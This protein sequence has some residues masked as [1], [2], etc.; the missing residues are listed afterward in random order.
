MA[1]RVGNSDARA[2]SQLAT[3]TQSWGWRSLAEDWSYVVLTMERRTDWSTAGAR[4]GSVSLLLLELTSISISWG[5]SRKAAD[6][7]TVSQ[8]SGRDVTISLSHTERVK[9]MFKKVCNYQDHYQSLG[10]F[11][12]NIFFPFIMTIS[13]L[14]WNEMLFS[15]LR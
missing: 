3:C 5:N 6:T 4:R 13:E 2:S 8:W 15:W 14:N 7:C 11:L 12:K 1:P 10:S 9:K